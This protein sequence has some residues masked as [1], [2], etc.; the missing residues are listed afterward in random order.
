MFASEFPG[1]RLDTPAPLLILAPEDEHT[2]RKLVPEFWQ[3]GGPKPAG[4]FFHG[5]EKQYALV[6][7]DSIRDGSGTD[8][9]EVV[10]HEY[11][12]TLLHMNFRW[13]PTWLDEGLA[14]YY[15]YTR[16]E[17][18]HTY[19]EAAPRNAGRFMMLRSRPTMPLAKFLEQRGS[20]TRDENDTQVYYAQCWA[21]THYLTLGPGMEQG[22]RLKKFFNQIQRGVPQLKAFQDTFG[23]L[24]KVQKDFDQYVHLFAFPAGVIPSPQQADEKSFSS[25]TMTVAE[26]AVELASFYSGTGHS[27]EARAASEGAV[28]ADPKLAL[29]HEVLGFVNLRE[30]NDAEA[31]RELSLAVDLDSTMHRSLFAKTMLSPLSHS[32]TAADRQTFQ[33]ELNKV[34]DGNPQFAPAYVELAKSAIA[35]G[36]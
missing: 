10:Y 12:H 9:F 17:G 24:P 7:L 8:S 25:R 20:F 28:K 21:L 19:V 14:E 30:G 13:L 34:L 2:T 31:A 5:W 3:H 1:F 4:I 35:K 36:T 26:S 16:F 15:A 22:V 27:R 11:L 32:T 6:R 18:N 29:A 33:A 23:E